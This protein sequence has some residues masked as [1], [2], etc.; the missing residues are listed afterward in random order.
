M[1]FLF[2]SF[3]EEDGEKY[4]VNA[5]QYYNNKEYT[6]A[7]ELCN[8]SIEFNSKKGHKLLAKLYQ[9]GLGCDVNN[10][11]AQHHFS[12]SV[13]KTNEDK[14][15]AENNKLTLKNKNLE[16]DYN[17]LKEKNDELGKKHDELGKNYEKLIKEKKE[18]ALDNDKYKRS[19][20]Y[21]NDELLGVKERLFKRQ[22]YEE[23]K[24]Y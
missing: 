4:Y 22:R 2:R 18:L 5:L 8:K 1:S 10:K 14:L 15:M 6:R 9:Q 24:E 7:F 19:I 11:L 3:D 20:Q 17:T 16:N 23:K 13:L 21:K 12:L